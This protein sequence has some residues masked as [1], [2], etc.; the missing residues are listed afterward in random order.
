MSQNMK[1]KVEVEVIGKDGKPKGYSAVERDLILYQ[2]RDWL[3]AM[4]ANRSTD[5]AYCNINDVSGTLR[6]VHVRGTGATY[7]LFNNTTH[8]AVG[9][10][11]G[12][13]SDGTAPSRSQ[14]E[15]LS[16]IAEFDITVEATTENSII[17]RGAWLATGSGT[18][19]ETG[20]YAYWVDSAGVV[21]QFLLF[22]DTPTPQSYVDGDSIQVT[23]TIT[24]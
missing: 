15:L 11:I 17:K 2:F 16:K 8:G 13:G 20:L 22:R 19:R 21:R 24:L 12:I 4:L 10:R 14:Y 23:Y 7:A 3:A 18:V 1:V 5:I 6:A 9:C